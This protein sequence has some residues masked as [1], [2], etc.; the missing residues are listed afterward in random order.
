VLAADGG[1]LERIETFDERAAGLDCPMVSVGDV[2]QGFD[3]APDRM[4]VP[5]Q[6]QRTPARYVA[7]QSNFV[8]PSSVRRV[9][10]G[11]KRLCGTDADRT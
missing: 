11:E 6:P 5:Q 8:R 4:L 1:V 7:V 2:A 9:S 10:R 3:I